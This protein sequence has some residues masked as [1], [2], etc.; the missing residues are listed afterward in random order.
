MVLF[1]CRE[2]TT[3]K[4]LSIADN[5]LIRIRTRIL[6]RSWTQMVKQRS[7]KRKADSVLSGEC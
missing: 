1:V 7:A 5:G 6:N 4:N 2:T 3:N